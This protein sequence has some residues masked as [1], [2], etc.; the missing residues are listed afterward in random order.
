MKQF[1]TTLDVLRL[2]RCISLL[3]TAGIEAENYE[4]KAIWYAK[5]SLLAEKVQEL[6]K[7]E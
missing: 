6:L 2:T 1:E 5:A 7:G 4:I 3:V